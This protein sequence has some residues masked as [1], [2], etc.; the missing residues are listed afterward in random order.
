MARGGFNVK[1]DNNVTAQLIVWRNEFQ[2][3]FSQEAITYARS[4]VFRCW[5]H[6]TPLL[7]PLQTPRIISATLDYTKIIQSVFFFSFFYP[8]KIIRKSNKNIFIHF[9]SSFQLWKNNSIL[10]QMSDSF[11]IIPKNY[12]N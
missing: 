10:K 1:T 4:R 9:N 2:L 5:C 11:L 8:V 6:D 12:S 3:W 7:H